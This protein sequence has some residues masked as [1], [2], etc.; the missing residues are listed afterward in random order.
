MKQRAHAWVALRALKMLDDW[1]E[2]PKLVELISSY[3]SEVWDGAWLPD[4]RLYDMNYGH[5]YK[6]DSDPKFIYK[7][8]DKEERYV[9]SYRDLDDQLVG[10]RLCLKYIKNF[11]ELNKPYRSHPKLGG[12]LPD[13]VIALSHNIGDMLKM[14][15]Y[16]LAKHCQ[17][18]KKKKRGNIEV[19]DASGNKRY[20]AERKISN[21]SN[22]PNFSARHI[23]LTLFI[24]SHYICDAHMPLHCDLR[25]FKIP[26]K[27]ARIPKNIHVWTERLWEPNFPKKESLILT[28]YTKKTL[29]KILKVPDTS[30]ISIDSP[31]S[32]YRLSNRVNKSLKGDEWTELI[33]TTRVSYA[34]ARKWIPESNNWF[35]LHQQHFKKYG[36]FKKCIL[37]GNGFGD[38]SFVEDFTHVTNAIFH[39]VIESIARIWYKAWR[40]FID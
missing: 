8:L 28:R 39:D 7:N 29:E 25:D 11:G 1:G 5:I 6:M 22:S 10:N 12:H 37:Q 16:P 32:D 36:G 27:G 2:A 23:A 18:Y 4:I 33:Y 31:N 35:D 20:L 24:L 15:D 40:R 19:I 9:K 14:S 34:V 30:I 21:L 38:G 26:R 3:I 17:K 13:R